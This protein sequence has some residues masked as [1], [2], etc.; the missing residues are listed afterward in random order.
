MGLKGGDTKERGGREG[1]LSILDTRGSQCVPER[2]DIHNL[3]LLIGR[4]K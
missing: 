1:E 2:G 3:M 4:L